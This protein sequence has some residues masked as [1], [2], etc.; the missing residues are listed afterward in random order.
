MSVANFQGSQLNLSALTKEAYAI[1]VAA[2]SYLFY[3]AN[4]VITL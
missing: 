2:K 3:L 1:Y 4:A